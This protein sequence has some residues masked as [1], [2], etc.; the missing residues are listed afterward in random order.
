MNAEIN[1][2]LYHT[3]QISDCNHSLGFLKKIS[4]L[5]LS[6]GRVTDSLDAPSFNSIFASFHTYHCLVTVI[7]CSRC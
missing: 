7:F 6:L 5:H 3:P 4:N 1:R 2:Y